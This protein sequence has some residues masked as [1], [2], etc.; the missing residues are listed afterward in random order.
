MKNTPKT[1]LYLLTKQTSIKKKSNYPWVGEGYL[2]LPLW[3]ALA[4]KTVLAYRSWSCLLNR[5]RKN[6]DE[7]DGVVLP[8]LE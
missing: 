7:K 1:K 8:E 6:I 4:T 3:S 5:I 2:P